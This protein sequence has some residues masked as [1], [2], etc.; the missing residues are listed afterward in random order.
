MYLFHKIF[1]AYIALH[2][3]VPA[4]EKFLRIEEGKY[5]RNIYMWSW[6]RQPGR[7]FVRYAKIC[8]KPV[9]HPPWVLLIFFRCLWKSIFGMEPLKVCHFQSFLKKWRC[10]NFKCAR[11]ERFWKRMIGICFLENRV[12]FTIKP[13]W[14]YLP[15]L[16][17]FRPFK[18]Q[19]EP[20]SSFFLYFDPGN[21]FL[22]KQ[23]IINKIFRVAVV[24]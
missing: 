15:L 5:C 1:P 2:S 23:Y 7:K 22:I 9:L 19:K 8:W 20:P 18:E 6:L 17:P 16:S 12:S 11:F 4:T 24:K 21:R 10:S 3:R 14:A 13:T